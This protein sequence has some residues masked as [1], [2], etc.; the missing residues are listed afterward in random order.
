MSQPP[1]HVL[2]PLAGTNMVDA[3]ETVSCIV[4][5][6]EALLSAPTPDPT[7]SSSSDS[8]SS[9]P[10]RL[11]GPAG[12]QEYLQAQGVRV[13]GWPGWQRLDASEVEAG[14]SLGKSREKDT[15]VQHMLQVAL[16]AAAAA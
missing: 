8:S 11:G 16:P 14:K 13:V 10:A 9:G 4:E 6:T 2:P 12:L 5:D 15:N 7:S 3:D 1:I